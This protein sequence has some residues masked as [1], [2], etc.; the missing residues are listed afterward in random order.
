[1]PESK[2]V[3]PAS[4]RQYEIAVQ[5]QALERIDQ[6]ERYARQCELRAASAAL[7]AVDAEALLDAAQ[8]YRRQRDELLQAFYP[9]GNVL[10]R[11]EACGG[12]TET[13]DRRQRL[14][15]RADLYFIALALLTLAIIVW[16]IW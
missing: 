3:D 7:D 12:L 5:S 10:T 4:A 16:R 11:P 8:E 13:V 15:R 6:L 2:S 9:L 1:M 14:A